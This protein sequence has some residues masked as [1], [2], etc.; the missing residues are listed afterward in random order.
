[1]KYVL[2]HSALN[3][4]MSVFEKLR[5]HTGDGEIVEEYYDDLSK[6]DEKPALGEA[7]QKCKE[8]GAMLLIIDMGVVGGDDKPLKKEGVK[9]KVLT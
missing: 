2:Y 9:L 7:L 3:K 4:D 1:M 8:T 6:T 5:Q